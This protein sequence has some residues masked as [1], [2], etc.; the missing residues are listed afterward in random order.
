M[1]QSN[2][3]FYDKICPKIDV[4][5]AALKYL[6]QWIIFEAV[7]STFTKI[8]FM[9]KFALACLLVATFGCQNQSIKTPETQR[10]EQKRPE[11]ALSIHG[12]AGTISKT[13]LTAE[14]RIAYENALNGALNIGEAILKN[15]G[16]ALDAVTASVSSLE[17]CPLFNAGA[18]QNRASEKS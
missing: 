14:K 13:E 17:D 10:I 18:G 7:F 12:G 16:S 6:F 8:R 4:R 5:L 9:K 15:G 2:G 3:Q 1:A 11:F